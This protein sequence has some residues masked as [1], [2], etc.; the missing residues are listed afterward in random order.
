M[1]TTPAV[2]RQRVDD[3]VIRYNNPLFCEDTLLVIFSKMDL[4][5][6]LSASSVCKF[7]SRTFRKRF[8]YQCILPRLQFNP[9]KTKTIL[10]HTTFRSLNPNYHG[11]DLALRFKA[12]F[13]RTEIQCLNDVIARYPLIDAL[14]IVEEGFSS[15]P[16]EEAILKTRKLRS[17]TIRLGG[18]VNF[19]LNSQICHHLTALQKL[20]VQQEAPLPRDIFSHLSLLTHLDLS[21]FLP[22]EGV[23]CLQGL[24]HLTRLEFLRLEKEE[25]G[26]EIPPVNQ[27]LPCLRELAL[28]LNSAHTRFLHSLLENTTLT[29][30][31]LAPAYQPLLDDSFFIFS[32]HK[33][34]KQITRLSTTS[35]SG[36]DNF[37]LKKKNLFALVRH[38]P[39][40]IDF[41]G[42]E[43]FAINPQLFTSLTHLSLFAE[44]LESVNLN[45]LSGLT[46][47]HVAGMLYHT[48]FPLTCLTKL[49]QL[50]L[51]FAPHSSDVL[52]EAI[53]YNQ[54]NI[55]LQ[56]QQFI[57][58]HQFATV[59]SMGRAAMLEA[60][61]KKNTAILKQ[62]ENENFPTP[63]LFILECWLRV[64]TNAPYCLQF[65]YP[66]WETTQDDIEKERNS[67][68]ASYIKMV[69][70][71][72][73]SGVSVKTCTPL[74]KSAYHYVQELA[75]LRL[76]P[77]LN[78]ALAKELETLK[79]GS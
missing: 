17:L 19:L 29:A 64:K 51:T 16:V 7:W 78:A 27:R 52:V 70:L 65:I 15:P 68:M 36:D 37:Y 32:N 54:I 72:L 9:L 43:H 47:L 63:L 50:K 76:K 55:A 34:L 69:V 13:D 30:L 62:F 58:S 3:A 45:L 38:L 12:S 79:Q 71:L 48:E 60:L 6:M 42:N 23:S 1:I 35:I 20:V 31:T 14:E 67:L 5:T 18:K 11:E 40:L 46:S 53:Y 10:F 2:K 22:D 28:Y 26:P 57:T 73:D 8:N 41:Q 77:Y 44:N 4:G 66:D 74:G 33:A 21:R 61:L 49:D 25:L 56:L 59:L 75:E 39:N 24:T